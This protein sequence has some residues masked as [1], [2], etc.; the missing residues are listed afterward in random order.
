M[1][2]LFTEKPIALVGFM[3]SGKSSV[4]KTL[5]KKLN[6]PFVDTD[7]EMERIVKKP[8]HHYFK[9]CDKTDFR[10]LESETLSK[11]I[12]QYRQKPVVIA[13]GGG[14]LEREN[15]RQL[16]LKDCL[17]IH[18]QTSFEEIEKRILQK[19][20]NHHVLWD[21]FADRALYNRRQAIYAQAHRV[22]L[23]DQ[24]SPEEIVDEILGGV[25]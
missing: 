10:D 1:K 5:A 2:K 11:I 25:P 4:G 9:E 21:K 13:T 15:N 8:I 22:V 18:L 3:S 23:T 17:V 6:L 14:I 16:L 20:S 24:K 7:E 19:K 12:Q